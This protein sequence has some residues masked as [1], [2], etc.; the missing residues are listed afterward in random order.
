VNDNQTRQLIDRLRR[1]HDATMNGKPARLPEGAVS[2]LDLIERRLL[3]ALRRDQTGTTE[4]DGYPGGRLGAG[5]QDAPQSSTEGAVLAGYRVD[6]DID[7]DHG[8]WAS[9]EHDTHHERTQRAFRHLEAAAEALRHLSSTLDEIDRHSHVRREDPAGHC[10]ACS[11]W[12]EGTEADRV[13]S[14]YCP[15][16]YRAWLRADRPDRARFER[17]RR[18][19]AA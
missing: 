17:E 10:Q 3:E 2:R 5:G 16:C 4:R 8:Y 7:M 18:Q 9:P 12:V 19:E 14:G 15:A 11:R 6:G 13:R 1:L